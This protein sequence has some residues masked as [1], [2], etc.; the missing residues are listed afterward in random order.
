MPATYQPKV[1]ML[2]GRTAT[3]GVAEMAVCYQHVVPAIFVGQPVGEGYMYVC[4]I[5]HDPRYEVGRVIWQHE[6]NS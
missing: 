3:W 6:L 1:I 2:N 5:T 4:A